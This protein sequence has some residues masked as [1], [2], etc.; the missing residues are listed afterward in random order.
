MHANHL[1]VV[2]SKFQALSIT[3]PILLCYAL[4][5]YL[6]ALEEGLGWNQYLWRKE[7]LSKFLCAFFLL[8]WAIGFPVSHQ[9]VNRF[10]HSVWQFTCE[11][12]HNKCRCSGTQEEAAVFFHS[13]FTSLGFLLSWKRN[14]LLK[15][16]LDIHY[17]PNGQYEVISNKPPNLNS[18]WHLEMAK[19]LS[20]MKSYSL[21]R[22]IF[23]I[24]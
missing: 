14:L 23:T 6:E 16:S 8:V 18:S 21:Q 11:N 13:D 5:N 12:S 10:H 1:S 2:T 20:P 17:H 19:A 7:D 22:L 9:L 15:N 4:L 24:L 3:L